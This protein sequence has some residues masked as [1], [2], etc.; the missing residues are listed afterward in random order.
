[1]FYCVFCRQNHDFVLPIFFNCFDYWWHSTNKLNLRENRLTLFQTASS[2]GATSK[3]NHIK[4]KK[5]LYHSQVVFC[6][7]QKFLLAFVSIRQIFVVAKQQKITTFH[8][9]YTIV[10]HIKPT[11]STVN[12]QNFFHISLY[13]VF[14]VAVCKVLFK[15]SKNTLLQP[16]TA[17][18]SEQHCKYNQKI[19]KNKLIFAFVCAIIL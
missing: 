10:Q 3:R 2:Q 1:M 13:M 5:R 11:T 14:P 15:T 7:I 18:K 4:I 17:Q 6:H 12:Q 19:L 16:N 8:T 9:V